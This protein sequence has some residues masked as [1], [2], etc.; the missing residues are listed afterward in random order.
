MT[1][2]NS[3]NSVRIVLTAAGSAALGFGLTG[4]AHAGS[5]N[6]DLTVEA[7]VTANCTVST[8]ALDFGDIDSMS[9][10]AVT[11][12]GGVSVTCTNGTT[13]TAAADAGDGASATFATRKMT[14]G[15]NTL[16]YSLYTTNSY[17]TVWGDG[18]SGSATIGNTG[19]G[20]AQAVTVYGRIPGGQSGVPAGSY[21][22]LVSVTITY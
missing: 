8:S 14:S 11:G 2:F 4:T 5:V 22:D 21:S 17:G 6:T 19:S 20:S 16:N 13:W 1:V 18:T 7:T 9:A 10:T 12:T 15:A 3:R